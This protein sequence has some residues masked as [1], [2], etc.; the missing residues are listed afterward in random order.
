MRSIS[1]SARIGNIWAR[2]VSMIDGFG[3]DMVM[4]FP[5]LPVRPAYGFGRTI[6]SGRRIMASVRSDWMAVCSSLRMIRPAKDAA[7]GAQHGGECG[8]PMCHNGGDYPPNLQWAR[9]GPGG[10]QTGLLPNIAPFYPNRSEGLVECLAQRFL[11]TGAKA[12]PFSF[13][14]WTVPL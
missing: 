5:R 2:R 7:A 11:R 1:A 4:K 13:A 3:S 14:P 12:I 9:E 6:S 10:S 8:V